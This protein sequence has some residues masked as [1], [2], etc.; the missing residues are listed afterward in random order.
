M[1]LQQILLKEEAIKGSDL[2][3]WLLEYD[4]FTSLSDD[5]IL[6]FSEQRYIT[7]CCCC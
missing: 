2:L 7:S 6:K 3:I 5:Q 1:K 4:K